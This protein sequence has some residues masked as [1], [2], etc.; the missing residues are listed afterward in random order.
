MFDSLRSHL[1]SAQR[2]EQVGV[3]PDACADAPALVLTGFDE[4]YDLLP[5]HAGQL[6][7]QVHHCQPPVD[8]AHPQVLRQRVLLDN[9]NRAQTN[10]SPGQV[11]CTV[12]WIK[13]YYS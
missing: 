4:V 8:T 12:T 11:N 10:Q 3:V 6:T 5:V 7:H 1:D 2:V 13:N 9:T